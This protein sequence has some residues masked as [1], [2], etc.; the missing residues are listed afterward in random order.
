MT[1]N[2]FEFLVE[3]GEAETMLTKVQAVLDLTRHHPGADHLE[4]DRMQ[5]KLNYTQARIDIAKAMID[6][7]PM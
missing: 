7:Y 6:V 1:I 2:P 3:L 4:L 5:T